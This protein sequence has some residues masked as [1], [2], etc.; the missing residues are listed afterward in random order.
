MSIQP[1]L[2]SDPGTNPHKWQELLELTEILSSQYS[3]ATLLDFITQVFKDHYACELHI[4]LELS[5]LILIQN[6][7]LSHPALVNQLS[8]VMEQVWH[9]KRLI[10]FIREPN[11]SNGEPTPVAIPLVLKE[12]FFGVIELKPLTSLSEINQQPEYYG[13][14]ISQISQAIYMLGHESQC[15]F[16]QRK[17]THLNTIEE[18]SKSIL[19][20]L[21]RESLLNSALS[22]IRLNFNIPKAMLF[23]S[24]KETND[25]Y[26]K[27]EISEEGIKTEQ[28]YNSADKVDPICWSISNLE[29]VIIN[30]FTL[31]ERF[32]LS[33][34]DSGIH[35]EVIFPLLNG[36]ILI[37]ALVLTSEVVDSFGPDTL[38]GFHM[39]AQN[40]SV[41][42][43]N[44]EL[45]YNE[46]VRRSIFDDLQREFGAISAETTIDNILQKL[47]DEVEE[48]IPC[49][50]AAIWLI[51]HSSGQN[52]VDRFT[53]TLQLG[54]VRIN[55]KS[56]KGMDQYHD[57]DDVVVTD[58]QPQN[59]TGSNLLM[60]QYQWI[61]HIVESKISLIK[62]DL[63]GFE[64]LG[65][66]LGFTDVYSAIGT[67]LLLENQPVGVMILVNHLGEQYGIDTRLIIEAVSRYSSIVIE[68]AQLYSAAHE[69]A[70]ISTVLLQVAEA[71]Q[72][73]NNI[74]E[75]LQTVA[76]I[77]PGLI[78]VAACLIYLWDPLVEAF[79]PQASK[80]FSTEQSAQINAWKIY[81][82]SV[83]AFDQLLQF[84]LPVIL[85]EGSL[86]DDLKTEV[87]PDRDFDLD[88]LILFPMEAQSEIVGA[89]L[90]DFTNSTLK[91][92]SSQDV[93]DEKYTLIEGIA[94]QTAITLE[95]LQL[96]KSQE[97]EAYISV[98]LLQVAQAIVS[99]TELDEILASIVRITPI[100]V[101]VKRC[102]LYLW[103]SK[104]QVF[105][106]SESF[107][108]LKSD[109]SI[110]GQVFKASEFPLLETILRH[111]QIMYYPLGSE[112]S[113]MNWN[114]VSS[115]DYYAIE[116]SSSDPEAEVTIKLDTRSLMG[117]ERL[118]VGFPL[119]IKGEMLGVMLI[120][121]EDPINGSPS[122]HIREKRI[123]I[124][125]GITQQAAIAI[126]NELLQQEAVKS[127]SMERELQLAREI[128]ATFLPEKL[129]EIPGWDIGA[130]WQPARQVG[131]DFYDILQVD[132]DHIGIVMADVADKG[133]PAALFMTLI[134]TLI[135]AAA[136]EKFSPAAVLKQVNTL[137][138][139]DSKH[140]MFVTVFYAVFSIS[141]GKVV[142]A[143]AGHNPP[144]V[145]HNHESE[146]VELTRTSIA[147]GIFDDIEIDEREIS[148]QY[149]D[150]I[151]LYTDGVTEAFSVN[152]EM[153]GEDRLFHILENNKFT[154]SQDLV[155]K[156]EQ[157][158]N[159]FI[160]GMDLS[161]DM[162]LAVVYRKPE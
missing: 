66:M 46:Q 13:D 55:K 90:V 3:L 71:T 76:D 24:L 144:I 122:L 15:E 121:E 124:V 161:D 98:A 157:S 11:S 95:N 67:P 32:E 147:L 56:Y 135:R 27:V 65:A 61:N 104:D 54:G 92:D 128:Q 51:D 117:H 127:E 63:P 94:R 153:F 108:I 17:I 138:I 29:P 155:T 96:I 20:N 36:E 142:Y 58:Q 118:L 52:G 39:L 158:V 151:L 83:R 2:H 40:I 59:S 123:E 41:A 23:I 5:S 145:N 12:Q 109:L 93:W 126:K 19:S 113:P 115:P 106:Q 73:I 125:R 101:G 53:S 120:E 105:Q 112:V 160:T 38:L 111:N 84:K 148:I 9:D 102:I 91:K 159:E 81:P 137:L 50:A 116:G 31:E 42:I 99:L 28:W 152:D 129:P 1:S 7:D 156:I 47:F 72:S 60:N 86:P 69:Q 26:K 57:Q 43:R 70:W 79:L 18:I 8:P 150:W 85:G 30:N 82:G 141:T 132:G 10:H 131:G 45:Y 154:S 48:I 162:T 37:G 44:A 62:N 87:F 146:M 114:E 33:A 6:A 119:S 68:N 21:D 34:L 143:N 77:L 35:S 4:W 97:E 103:N 134:R 133:M 149:G 88:M 74:D 16:L 100:L 78:D 110:I 25:K 14:L 75:L 140:G 64:P 89:M 49:D 139:P 22:I 136:K 130:S 107:G 80:G